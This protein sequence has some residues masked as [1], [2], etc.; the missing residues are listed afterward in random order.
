MELID[1]NGDGVP[2][3]FERRPTIT[4]IL[5]AEEA[6][7]VTVEVNGPRAPKVGEVYI[8]SGEFVRAA[9]DFPGSFSFFIVKRVV[10]G[11]MVIRDQDSGEKG[12]WE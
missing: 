10:S 2:D 6:D 4:E 1:T 11:S 3:A 5:N 8:T 7:T 9:V 12:G